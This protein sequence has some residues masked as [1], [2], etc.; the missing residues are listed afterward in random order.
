[1][2]S[3]LGSRRDPGR[4]AEP[5]RRGKSCAWYSSGSPTPDKKKAL[6]DSVRSRGCLFFPS[7]TLRFL[8]D[9]FMRRRSR[10][11]GS[12]CTWAP[13]G[14]ICE[15][16]QA[17]LTTVF[18]RHLSGRKIV[19]TTGCQGSSGTKTTSMEILDATTF[20]RRCGLLRRRRPKCLDN[21]S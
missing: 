13:R 21:E 8:W 15:H 2:R 14:V 16:M 3:P 6:A 9:Y 1:M 5:Q 12:D 11:S 4:S 20:G 17:L 7:G 10:L 19:R 18:Q